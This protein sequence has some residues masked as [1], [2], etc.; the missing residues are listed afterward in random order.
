[1]TMAPAIRVPRMVST[2]QVRPRTCHSMWPP[3]SM[4]SATGWV[5]MPGY[6]FVRL[7]SSKPCSCRPSRPQAAEHRDRRAHQHQHLEDRQPDEHAQAVRPEQEGAPERDDGD[8]PQPGEDLAGKLQ[9][10]DRLVLAV[11]E[12][13]ALQHP[14]VEGTESQ[15]QA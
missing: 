14:V 10:P 5:L 7:V 13:R 6:A 2:F 3:T 1:M 11:L 8:Q 9:S 12:H 15:S 4:S